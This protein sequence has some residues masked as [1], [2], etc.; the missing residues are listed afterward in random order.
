[1]SAE[2]SVNP[3]MPTRFLFLLLAGYTLLAGAVRI[4]G[5]DSRDFWFD[6][7]CTHL[8]VSRMFDWPADSD[9]FAESNATPYYLLLKGWVWLFGWSET[10][11]R[12][13]SALAAA[14]TVFPLGWLAYHLGGRYAARMCALLMVV[15][16]LHVYYSHSARSYALVILLLSLAMCFL[17][18]AV[19]TKRWRWWVAYGCA[20]A[21]VLCTH[22]F[23]VHWAVASIS[24]I[25]LSRRR[26]QSFGRWFVATAL[27]AAL[28]LPYLILLSWPSSTAGG[29]AWVREVWDP[30]WSIPRSLWAFLPAG[31]Y[32]AYLGGLSLASPDTTILGPP[33]LNALAQVLPAIITAAIVL[34]LFTRGQPVDHGRHVGPIPPTVHVFLGGLTILPLVTLWLQSVL[35]DPVYVVARYDMSAWP[36]AIVWLSVLLSQFR[37][38]WMARRNRVVPKV[39]TVVLVACALLPLARLTLMDAP[40]TFHRLRAQRLAELCDAGDLVISFTYDRE[41]LLYYLDRFGFTG[42]MTSF[43]SWIDRHVGWIDTVSDAAPEREVELERDAEAHAQR[44]SALLNADGRVWILRDFHDPEGTS[45]RAPINARLI[46]ALYDEGFSLELADGNTRIYRVVKR[47]AE[48]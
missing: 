11:Y 28:F 15:H 38:S 46:K 29:N 6:E 7:S 47:L 13:L 48:E 36:A 37:R 45:L 31:G 14:L 19:C 9:F 21:F 16:P 44:V 23:T 40:A 10:G 26:T 42:E 35:L 33:L 2:T 18:R 39:V 20:L 8:Y 1:M 34:W 24:C 4:C 25:A 5:I 43:P 22:Y 3:S 12:S 27:A 30:V 17:Y 41:Y 32:P